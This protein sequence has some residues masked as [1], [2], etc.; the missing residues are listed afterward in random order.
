[1]VFFA[2]FLKSEDMK[3][4]TPSDI[5]RCKIYI[6]KEHR[7]HEGRKVREEDAVARLN[8]LKMYF[9]F[10]HEQGYL[11]VD[12][13]ANVDIPSASPRVRWYIPTEEDAEEFASKP[14][15]YSYVGIRD[16]A[17][18][19]L[20]YLAPLKSHE[21]KDLKVQDIDLEKK[22]IY[23]RESKYRGLKLDEK[24]CKAIERYLKVSRPV[25]AKKSKPPTD[26]LFLNEWGDSLV[27]CSIFEVFYKYRGDKKL[28]PYATRNMT[29]IDMLRDGSSL[30]EVKKALGIKSIKMC[31]AYKAVIADDVSGF[32]K[33]NRFE[34]KV[35]LLKRQKCEDLVVVP[36]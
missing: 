29:A 22:T 25:F 20:W 3:N 4:I 1:V 17:M 33:R 10:L 15:P 18:I 28:K 16:A 12:P 11:A 21:Q 27:E 7:N 13:A 30:E 26:K 9:C 19:R 6:F 23:W 8:S 14:D 24:T 34:E 5:E 35:K 2:R 32:Y 31:E 36:K